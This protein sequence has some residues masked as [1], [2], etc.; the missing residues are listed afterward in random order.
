MRT[1]DAELHE[2]VE[3]PCNVI[4]RNRPFASLS[5][6]AL[7][8]LLSSQ[9][10]AQDRDP[11]VSSTGT[12]FVIGN[13]GEVLTNSHV[14]ECNNIQIRQRGQAIKTSII[15]QDR[16][17]D[18]ALLKL[19]QTPFANLAI[20]AYPTLRVGEQVVTFGFP[21]T[22]AL[23]TDGGAS[24]GNVNALAGL[25]N[26]VRMLQISVPVQPGNSGGPLLD[27][28]GNVVGIVASKLNALRAAQATGDIAQNVNFAIKA[29][30]IRAFL[31]AN[32]VS[33][34][35]AWSLTRREIADIAEQAKSQTLLVECLD[36]EPVLATLSGKGDLL[37]KSDAQTLQERSITMERGERLGAILR[38]LGAWPDEITA[39]LVALGPRGRDGALKEG[40]K[41]RVLLSPVRGSQRLQ[42]VRV[43]LVG[44]HAVEAVV[45]LSDL[46]RYVSVLSERYN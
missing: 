36:S 21:L 46:G 22:G 15:A 20:R 30:I 12:G 10:P 27:I 45:A 31:D 28:S 25:S 34:R 23:A 33:Y 24:V 6:L 38:D 16:N 14:V 26:D 11:A 43:T 7:T 32:G 18:L 17:N 39:I 5:I 1:N 40:Q 4:L 9:A 42:P 35:T 19:E 37:R 44:E 29:S 8:I 13:R 41:L 2:M 3:G